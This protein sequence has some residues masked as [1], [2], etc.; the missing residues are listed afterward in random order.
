MQKNA[1]EQDRN[2]LRLQY[3]PGLALIG[4]QTTGP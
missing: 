1:F 2:K 3:N 4:L